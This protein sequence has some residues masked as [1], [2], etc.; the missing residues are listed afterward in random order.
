MD[1]K[2]WWWLSFAVSVALAVLIGFQ[3]YTEHISYQPNRCQ[4]VDELSAH[5]DLLKKLRQAG[6]PAHTNLEL[7]PTG[8]FIQSLEFKDANDVNLTGY[9]WQRY[10]TKDFTEP[11][12]I[13]FP[14]AVDSAD[15]LIPRNQKEEYR[16]NLGGFLF[17]GYIAARRMHVIEVSGV[18]CQKTEER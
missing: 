12:G 2:I 1:E 17:N 15:N 9:V 3:W 8:V 13:V 10:D 4:L 11:P 5:N 18:R 16:H 14:E 6:Y 7:V